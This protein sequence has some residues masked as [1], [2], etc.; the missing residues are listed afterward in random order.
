MIRPVGA[1][2]AAGESYPRV[3]HPPAEVFGGTSTREADMTELPFA[4][5][6]N[7]LTRLGYAG[8]R[9]VVAVWWEECGDELAFADDRMSACGRG[10]ERAY[11]EL[12][13]RPEVRDWLDANGVFLGASDAPATHWL[14][15][16]AHTHRA[17]VAPWRDAR[18]QVIWQAVPGEVG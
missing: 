15:V 4:L 8:G 5:P 3:G 17:W 12:V 7:F 13:R 6:A 14:V 18:Q 16:D 2:R 11:R 9:Q 10:D 1:G